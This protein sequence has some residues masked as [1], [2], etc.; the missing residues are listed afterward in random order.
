MDPAIMT[1]A[2][3]V[4]GSLVG[5]LTSFASSFHTQRDAERR[6]RISQEVDGRD[7]LYTQFNQ[8]ASELLVDSIDHSLD[9]QAKLVGIM[10]LTGRI[11][12]TSTKSVLQAA[13][14]LI[15]ELL[16]SYAKPGDEGRGAIKT[17]P[18]ELVRPLVTFTEA[19]RTERETA[20][21]RLN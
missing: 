6:K 10:T 12:L 20:L 4:C 21:L 14:G 16:A 18:D 7:D 8:L 17:I 15:A 5:G 13:E 2:A 11:R 19:C 3:A 9:E 1:A